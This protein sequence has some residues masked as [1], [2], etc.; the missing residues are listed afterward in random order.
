MRA[1]QRG[2]RAGPETAEVLQ[3]KL[4]RIE[5]AEAEGAPPSGPVPRDTERILLVDDE[6]ALVEILARVLEDVGFTVQAV[7]DPIQ[8]LDLFRA[9]PASYDLVITDMTMP[10]MTG[11]KLAAELLRCRPDVPIILCTGFSEGMSASRAQA[12]GIA[13][14]ATKPLSMRDLISRIRQILDARPPSP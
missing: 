9:A 8:A 10:R 6:P 11:D 3:A 1:E 12:I 5:R 4:A 13:D 14:F 2:S 7:A